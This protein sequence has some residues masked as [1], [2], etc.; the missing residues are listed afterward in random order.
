[1]SEPGTG[2]GERH[3]CRRPRRRPGLDGGPRRRAADLRR[4]PGV[5]RPGQ[6]D[7]VADAQRPRALGPARARRRRVLRRRLAVLAVRRPARPV[8][9]DWSGWPGPTMEQIGAGHPRDRAPQRHP[10]RP[11]RA[12][13]AG[14]LPATSSAPAT[15]PRSTCPRTARRSARSSTR[16]ARCRSRTG[17]LER[18]TDATITDP[19]QLRRDGAR[20]RKRGWALTEDELE[21]GLTGIAVPVRGIHGDVVAALG[22]S[23][24]TPR[25]EG[26]LD[27]LG[28][29]LLGPRR[30]S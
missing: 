16:G 13:R 21:V 24:P 5:E 3:P 22:I 4:P 11:G 28:R 8:G 1:M 29:H 9:R 6:V 18:L 10:R 19:E 7:G 20:A 27:E 2:S 30:R 15:G 12:G 26:R 23:G 14:R 25:L 17:P